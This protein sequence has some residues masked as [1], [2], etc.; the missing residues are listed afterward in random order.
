MDRLHKVHRPV[1]YKGAYWLWFIIPAAILLLSLG[2][3]IRYNRM[4]KDMAALN[5]RRADKIARRRLRKAAAAMKKKNRDLFYD[6][7]LTALWGYLGDKLKMPTSELLRDNIRQTLESRNIPEN[8]T[9][10]LIALVDEAEFAKYSSAGG[11]SAMDR[12]YKEAIEAI[13]ELEDAFRKTKQ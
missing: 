4:H 8:V 10:R 2:L 9:E 13:N 7:L 5:M 12:D 11:D 1:V 6:E 3:W